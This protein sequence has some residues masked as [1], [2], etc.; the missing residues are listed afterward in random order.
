M[1]GATEKQLLEILN[2][3]I[4]DMKFF[5]RCRSSTWSS[6]EHAIMDLAEQQFKII[7]EKYLQ[8]DNE[9]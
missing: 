7:F 6:S 4:W 9:V 2:K 5:F 8:D 3:D 1:K